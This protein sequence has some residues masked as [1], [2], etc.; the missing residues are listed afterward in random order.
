MI[1][2]QDS[3]LSDYFTTFTVVCALEVIYIYCTCVLEILYGG[4]LLH[5]HFQFS[6]Q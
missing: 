1:N 6:I 4:V 2:N 3:T 5:V